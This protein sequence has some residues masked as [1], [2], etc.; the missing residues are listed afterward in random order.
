MSQDTRKIRPQER[1]LVEHLLGL[2]G[3]TTAQYPIREDVVEYEGAKWG[4]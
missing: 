2:I 4:V 1:A 3:F